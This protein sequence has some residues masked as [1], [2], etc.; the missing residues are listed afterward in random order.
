MVGFDSYSASLMRRVEK[1]EKKTK[2]KKK[3]ASIYVL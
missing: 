1:K 2:K 3:R